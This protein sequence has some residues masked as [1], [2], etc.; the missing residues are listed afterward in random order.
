VWSVVVG[1]IGT[2]VVVLLVVA[3]WPDLLRLPPLHTLSPADEK[4]GKPP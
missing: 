3:R 1:G 4:G 2:V